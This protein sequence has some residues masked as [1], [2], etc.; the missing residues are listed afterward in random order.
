M[1]LILV[2]DD[3]PAIRRMVTRMLTAAGHRIIE[4]AGGS[5]G[6]ALFL[7]ER[8]ALVI[9]DIVMEDG[10]GIETIRELR[11]LVPDIPILAMSGSGALYLRL[12]SNIGASAV[13]EKPFA[14][15]EFLERVNV[16]LDG[17]ASSGQTS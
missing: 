15:D 13:L 7:R 6:M 10:E 16:L 9:T 3:N 1:P 8:P 14:K 2:I 5:E 11:R 4:A 17:V 12:A